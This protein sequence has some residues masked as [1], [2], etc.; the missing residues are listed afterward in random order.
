MPNARSI[1]AGAAYVELTLSDSR[2]VRGLRRAQA[3]LN[4]FGRSAN[5]MGRR[6]VLAGG[7]AA[8][9]FA[10]AT[11]VFANFG[12][13]MAK[14]RAV[15]GAT[16]ADFAS[17]EKQAKQ[18]GRT[19][20][21]TASQVAEGMLALGRAGLDPAQIEAATPKV[22]ALARATDT[23]LG[24][25]AEIAAGAMRGFNMEA[26]EMGRVA[27]VLTATANGSAQTLTDLGESMKY[28]A[29]VAMEAGA[30]IE[31]VA[32]GLA[33]LANNAIKG[34]MAGTA[35]TR[36]YKNLA[37]PAAQKALGRL[38]VAAVDSAGDLRPLATVLNE[39]GQATAGM[40]SAARIGAFESLFGRASAAALKLGGSGAQFGDM[41]DK[42]LAANGTAEKTAATMDATLGGAFR[43]LMSS[44]EGV[45]I[46]V[47]ESLGPTIEKWSERITSLAGRITELVERNRGL[48]LTAAKITVGAIAV[49][50]ALVTAA[51]AA[52][53]LAVT[54]GA[55]AGAFALVGAAVGTLGTLL[56]ALLS[57][58]GLVVAAVVGLGAYFLTAGGQGLKALGWLGDKFAELKETAG[59]AMQGIK[60]ALA[61]GDLKL[62]ARVLWLTLK[63][64]WQKGV[65]W[66]QEK[67]I[68]FK[69]SFVRVWTDAVYALARVFTS[70]WA[71]IQALWV[72]AIAG[73]KTAWTN[74]SNWFIDKWEGAQEAVAGT[75][76]ASMARKEGQDPEAA[77]EAVAEDYARK[78]EARQK[79]QGHDQAR[80]DA[81][82]E[83]QLAK[84][85]QDEL[86]ALA[87]LDQMNQRAHAD[88]QQVYARQLADSQAALD[89][90]QRAWRD[91]LDTAALKKEMQDLWGATVPGEAAA[92]AV[93][94]PAKKAADAAKKALAGV[95]LAAP[96]SIAGTFS[97]AAVGGLGG[98]SPAQR[99]AVAA[100]KTA[101][102]TEKLVRKAQQSKLVF[103][104]TGS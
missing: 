92:D 67:W 40:G 47:G 6:L 22:L 21:F 20:S 23:E 95:D 12:D 102:N 17:L 54:F 101:E 44:I 49:G 26:D 70:G 3:R 33:I 63:L 73:L 84:I 46:A 83:A 5:D 18:L 13:Q 31:D 94:D 9:P 39:L 2:L 77:R 65:N 32:A 59:A 37:T 28:V 99:S 14:V 29:P 72:Q 98:G 16:E 4:A 41:R 15:T 96:V 7:A 45:A 58:V 85:G 60:D 90:A 34:S 104:G 100:E 25:A 66:L 79:T 78:R 64:Q 19:T 61:A 103:A 75:L 27:D 62:A 68:G 42:L 38:G 82:R 55:I 81:A 74:F 89:D 97:A 91:A 35:M 43:R 52:K 88:R 36:A 48:I 56:A 30:E 76:A 10:L 50:A 24:Q 11:R 51:V 86:A 69:E 8:T 1:R 80:I 71:G 57:P 87:T 53:L 93:K